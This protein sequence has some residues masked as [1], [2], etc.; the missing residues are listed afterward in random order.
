MPLVNG[1]NVSEDH[2]M[3]AVSQTV[4]Q[5]RLRVGVLAQGKEIT[6]LSSSNPLSSAVVVS[7]S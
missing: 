2:A 6:T 1:L 3:T 5:R 4:G 7:T